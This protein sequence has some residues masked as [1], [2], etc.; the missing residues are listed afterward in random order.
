MKIILSA[1]FGLVL[2]LA[3]MQSYAADETSTVGTVQSQ[4]AEEEE[5]DENSAAGII[6]IIALFTVSF[7]ASGIITY[8]VK[9]KK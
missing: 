1:L 8:K 2:M 5:K 6:I 7:A 3:P 4:T 9:T